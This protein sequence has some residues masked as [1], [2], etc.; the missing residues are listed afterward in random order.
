[1]QESKIN[2]SYQ[3]KIIVKNTLFNLLGYGVPLL[4][5]LFLIPL[6]IKG[7]GTEKFGILTIAWMMIGYFSF[8]DFGISKG[9]TKVIS[10]KIGLNQLEDIP[11][12]FWTSL[13]IMLIISGVLIL[14][15]WFFVPSLVN[16]FNISKPLQQET[17]N[18]FY[19][20]I[21]SIPVVSTSAGLTVTANCSGTATI[22]NF[23]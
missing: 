20:L 22:P 13:S 5:A 6:L 23:F 10:E 11:G 2:Q 4:F 8:F 1:M 12:I 9:L 14:G 7:L 15:S 21:L 16:T 17:V 18:T 19:I 3:G